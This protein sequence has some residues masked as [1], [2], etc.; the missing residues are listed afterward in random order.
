MPKHLPSITCF[1]TRK[2]SEEIIVAQSSENATTQKVFAAHQP[3]FMPNLGF[4]HKMAQ[5]DIFVITTNIQFERQE[6]WQRRNL[7]KD[8]NGDMWLTVPVL[9]TQKQKIKDVKIKYEPDWCKKHRRTLWMNYGESPGR[10]LLL[11][12]DEI[13]DARHE[14]LADLNIAFIKLIKKALGI[15]TQLIIDEDISGQKHEFMI[16]ICKKYGG[17]IYLSGNGVKSYLNDDRVLELEENNIK[18]KF[19]EETPVDKYTYS[20]LHYLLTK[21]EQETAKLI[22]GQTSV[23]QKFIN[24]LF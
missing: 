23:S 9:G 15:S 21:G 12:V 3:N 7:F 18:H 10:N 13:Y 1:V 22:N 20:A 6:G 14:R 2:M 5:A 24:S 4:F 8:N 11:G 17:D 16:N 19:I